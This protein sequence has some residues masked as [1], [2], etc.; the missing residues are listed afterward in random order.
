MDEP[1]HRIRGLAI[2]KTAGVS[3]EERGCFYKIAAQI[4]TLAAL[5]IPQCFGA[6]AAKLIILAL[7]LTI[8][9]FRTRI[10]ADDPVLLSWPSAAHF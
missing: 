1:N 4:G 7:P 9:G 5:G 10:C 6:A 3:K 2:L 8:E